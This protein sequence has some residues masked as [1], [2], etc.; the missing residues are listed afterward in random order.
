MSPI[1]RFLIL[2][3]RIVDG[4][5]IVL[6]VSEFLAVAVGDGDWYVSDVVFYTV[7]LGAVAGWGFLS[8][9]RRFVGGGMGYW[10]DCL[11]F[12]ETVAKSTV[13]MGY[14]YVRISGLI[15]LFAQFFEL[16]TWIG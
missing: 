2:V 15:L 13:V 11:E 10:I 3:E 8:S 12:C 9:L 5:G 7:F 6:R 1:R 4:F 16:G 14:T